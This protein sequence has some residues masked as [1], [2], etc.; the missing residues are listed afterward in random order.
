VGLDRGL[1]LVDRPLALGQGVPGEQQRGDLLAL[2]LL[3]DRR[4]DGGGQSRMPS[5]D[6]SASLISRAMVSM[7]CWEWILIGL[8]FMCMGSF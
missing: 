7:Y 1:F 8:V 3:F 6:S 4:G 5:G 2:D